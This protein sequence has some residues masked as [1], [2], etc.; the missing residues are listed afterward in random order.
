MKLVDTALGLEINLSKA[1]A[2]TTCIHKHAD[3]QSA[4]FSTRI[5]CV[6]PAR[7]PGLIANEPAFI[8]FDLQSSAADQH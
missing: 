4:R 6:Y 2:V 7:E 1:L 3:L 5:N 8:R